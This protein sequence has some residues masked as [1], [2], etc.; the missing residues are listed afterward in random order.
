MP[1]RQLRRLLSFRL[2][3]LGRS[4]S[5]DVRQPPTHRHA[6]LVRLMLY[7]HRVQIAFILQNCTKIRHCPFAGQSELLTLHGLRSL[8]LLSLLGFNTLG[9]GLGLHLPCHVCVSA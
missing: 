4:T 5:V 9:L 2:V 8:G 3:Q 7:T 6:S 1:P